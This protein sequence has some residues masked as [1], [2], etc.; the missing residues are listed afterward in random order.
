MSGLD[1]FHLL[2]PILQ[3]SLPMSGLSDDHGK[4]GLDEFHLYHE[5]RLEIDQQNLTNVQAACDMV[6]MVRKEDSVL[7][8]K[9]GIL[10]FRR[11]PKKT[12]K[13]HN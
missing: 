5:Y 4:S 10:P 8:S 1:G 7:I 6:N 3:K 13:N 9:P 11:V 2:E 12:K